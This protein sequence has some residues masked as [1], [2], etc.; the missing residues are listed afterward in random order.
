MLVV[1]FGA[2]VMMI[3]GFIPWNDVW[4]EVFGHDFP[5]PTFDNFYFT[6]ASVLFLVAAV[7]IGLIAKLGEEG[8]V[9]TIVAGAVGLPRRRAGHR[10]RPRHHGRDEEHLHHRHRPEL[11]GGRGLG[12]L[13]RAG[14]A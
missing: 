2:F 5:L 1:F 4:Q 14:S 8:T 11:D 12:L 13:G 7:V 10:A 6:E 9:N 3:Y